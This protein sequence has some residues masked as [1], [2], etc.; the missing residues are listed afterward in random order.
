MDISHKHKIL[1]DLLGNKIQGLHPVLFQHTEEYFKLLGYQIQ[2]EDYTCKIG[3][4]T[5]VFPKWVLDYFLERITG[6]YLAEK[7]YSTVYS[8]LEKNLSLI[9][10]KLN[11]QP[12]EFLSVTTNYRALASLDLENKMSNSKFYYDVVDNI[13]SEFH[14]DFKKHFVN[15]IQYQKKV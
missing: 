3:D 11:S 14:K 4:N 12:N 1:T 5:Y 7:Y 9:A 6:R 8:N 13:K 10:D 2:P 15:K